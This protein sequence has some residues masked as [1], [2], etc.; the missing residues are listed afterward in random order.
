MKHYYPCNQKNEDGTV[1]EVPVPFLATTCGE[2]G[3]PPTRWTENESSTPDFLA[4][5]A[6]SGF[7]GVK[8][9]DSCRCRRRPSSFKLHR[10]RHTER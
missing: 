5:P 3:I 1:C 6:D 7:S 8:D 10:K 4:T 9:L 2:H